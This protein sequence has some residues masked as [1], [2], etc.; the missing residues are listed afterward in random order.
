MNFKLLLLVVFF[1]FSNL[2]VYGYEVMSSKTVVSPG[3]EGGIL[4]TP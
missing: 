3:L 1:L 2:N 4:K